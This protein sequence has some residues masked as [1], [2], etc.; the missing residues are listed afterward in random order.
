MVRDTRHAR[1][2]IFALSRL[3]LGVAGDSRGT[4][5]LI[6]VA[7][8]VYQPCTESSKT[9]PHRSPASSAGR[10]PFIL[11]V[12][13]DRTCIRSEFACREFQQ[14]RITVNS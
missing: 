5:P 7:R 9:M 6:A 14:T 1:F 12:G 10:G 3:F 11:G 4:Q 8:P 2:A 13:C